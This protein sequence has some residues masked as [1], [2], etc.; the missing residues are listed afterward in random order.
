[1]NR[2]TENDG[3]SNLQNKIAGKKY[4]VGGATSLVLISFLH[5]LN[6]PILTFVN[7][8]ASVLILIRKQPVSV[9]PPT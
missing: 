3:L 8:A 2:L 7:F 6:I 4:K 9:Q 5:C 1:V